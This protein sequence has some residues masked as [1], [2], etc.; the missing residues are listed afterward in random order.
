MIR[1]TAE[2]SNTKRGAFNKATSTLPVLANQRFWGWL[3]GSTVSLCRQ[4]SKIGKSLST[5]LTRIATTGLLQIHQG[6]LTQTAVSPTCPQLEEVMQR[7]RQVA[8][9][10]GGHEAQ[11]VDACILLTLFMLVMALG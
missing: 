6:L 8:D 2:A 1:T 9:L 11:A 7:I 4:S 10:K 5:P 3:K